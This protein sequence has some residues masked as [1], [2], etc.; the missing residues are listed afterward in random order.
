[1]VK[2]LGGAPVNLKKKNKSDLSD[3]RTLATSRCRRLAEITASQPI[4]QADPPRQRKGTG[5]LLSWSKQEHARH[6]F[7]RQN[8]SVVGFLSGLVRSRKPNGLKDPQRAEQIRYS[9]RLRYVMGSV[10]QVIPV[11]WSVESNCLEVYSC[12]IDCTGIS[13]ALNEANDR[14]Q[15]PPRINEA[16]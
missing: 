7:L 6:G 14:V 16:G 15:I 8:P 5:K 12:H 1:M 2:W 9:D 13:M 10:G 11:W 4:R 3:E